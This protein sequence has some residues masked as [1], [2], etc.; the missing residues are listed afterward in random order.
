MI[1]QKDISLQPYNT[2]GVDVNCHQLICIEDNQEIEY[3]FQQHVFDE[4]FFVIGGG[5]N[6]L[7]TKD[8]DGTIIHMATR[9]IEKLQETET[10]VVVKVAAGESWEDFVR[11]CIRNDY[12][13]VENL[14]G[15][16]GLVGSSAV[17]NIGAY[18]VEVKDVILAVEGVFVNN[19]SPFVFQNADCKFSYRNSIFKTE[20]KNQC[21]ITAVVFKLSKTENYSLS[22]FALKEELKRNTLP[23][24]LENV[25][26][27]VLNIRNSKLPDVRK[28][29]SAGSFFK[30]PLVSQA[31]LQALLLDSPNL[32]HY[33]VDGKHVKL[34]A[35]QLIEI[36][37][38][39]GVR[40]GNVGVYPYQALVIVN[41][42]NASG[43]EILHFSQQIQEDVFKRFQLHLEAEVNI[44]D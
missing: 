7:F 33:P 18:G 40:K 35:G 19:A 15:V 31:H 27:S 43:E 34:A 2:F 21:L 41:Y 12:Y 13:G 11:F 3:L 30:N 10:K 23:L 17:Q 42:G 6:L 24:C 25:A 36:A 44:I 26:Q 1:L 16:P 20:L 4:T 39:K 8:F 5:S 32:T 22:Y 28:I 9:G 37:G 14:V 29:G 38:W